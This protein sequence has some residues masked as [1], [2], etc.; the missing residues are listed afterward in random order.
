V[1]GVALCAVVAACSSSSKA[2]TSAAPLATK[3]DVTIGVSAPIEV[4][5]LPEIALLNGEFAKQNLNVT[6]KSVPS[7]SVPQ[8]LAQGTIQIACSGL[9]GA[10]LNAIHSGVDLRIVGNAVALSPNDPSGLWV[11]TKFLNSDGSLKK[12]FPSDFTLSLGNQGSGAVSAYWTQVYL[13]K[14][15][16]S[17]AKVRNVNLSQP[18]IALALRNGSLDAGF[19]NDPYSG[20]LVGNPSLRLVA[21]SGAALVYESTSQYATQHADVI[22]AVLRGMLQATKDELA[23]GYRNNT[24]VMGQLSGWLHVPVATIDKAP[25]PVFLSTMDLNQLKPVFDGVQTIWIQGGV[26]DYKS[27]ISYSSIT[28]AGPLAAAVKSIK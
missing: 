17:L 23:P 28:D 5:A 4:E 24:T 14:N 25:A 10:M 3:T 7:A 1:S 15:G 16:E 26:V 27:P 8:L 20:T 21:A 2:A 12:P 19:A 22:A 18:D 9:S 6:V 11:N 13:Q